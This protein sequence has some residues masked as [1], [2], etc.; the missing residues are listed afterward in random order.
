MLALLRL[1]CLVRVN[2]FNMYIMLEDYIILGSLRD[3]CSFCCVGVNGDVISFVGA[4]G[5][6]KG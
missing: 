4:Y 5:E 1:R 6:R 2:R 3:G